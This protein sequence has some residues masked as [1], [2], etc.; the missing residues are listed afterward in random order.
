VND[1]HGHLVG[2]DFLSAM[3]RII[4]NA[5]RNGDSVFRYGGDEFVIL[6]RK[7]TLQRSVDVAERLRRK[8]EC[9]KFFI[10]GVS[11]NTTVSIGLAVFP[12]HARQVD[13]LIHLADS[14]MYEAKKTRNAVQTAKPNAS[15]RAPTRRPETSL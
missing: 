10:R 5:V 13:R 14:A 3:G 12:E 11:L 8:I 4:K 6:L 15:P 1:R 9:R 7:T 2:S